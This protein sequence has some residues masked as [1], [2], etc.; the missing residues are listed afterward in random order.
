MKKLSVCLNRW[1]TYLRNAVTSTPRKL[2]YGLTCNTL[3]TFNTKLATHLLHDSLFIIIAKWS[4]KFIIVH[5]WPIFLN[6]PATCHLPQKWISID[7]LNAF[8]KQILPSDTLFGDGGGGALQVQWIN[9]REK[10]AMTQISHVLLWFLIGHTDIHWSRL[11]RLQ[12]WWRVGGFLFV[13]NKENQW[14]NKAV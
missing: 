12:M 10:V 14:K 1:K 6:P 3:V 9:T 2:T 11:T 13:F 5:S 8:N 4:A 7:L